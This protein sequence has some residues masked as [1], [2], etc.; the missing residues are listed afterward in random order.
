MQNLAQL[1]PSPVSA[2]PVIGRGI[3]PAAISKAH[4]DGQLTAKVLPSV[5]AV[6][7]EDWNALFP[8]KAED[9]DYFRACELMETPH[10]SFSA[11]AVFDGEMLVAA[12]PIFRMKF[13]LD[14]PLG[15]RVQKLGDWL[16]RHVPKL[17]N[18]PILG[19][20]S[21]WSD[22]CPLG[23]RPGLSADERTAAFEALLAGLSA[24]A[25][26]SGISIL[27][28]KDV[29]SHDAGWAHDALTKA[30]YGR[31]A[32]L[33][34]ASVD[35]PFKN[36]KEF[37]AS[38]PA[39]RR[40]DL[41]RNL[42]SESAVTVEFRDSIEDVY[43]E[44]I[45]LYNQTR[46]RRSAD[47]QSFDE[48]PPGYFKEVMKHLPGKAKVA[49]FRIG[50]ELAGFN[51]FLVGKGE[52]TW[53]F[54]GLQYPLALEHHL[55]FVSWMTMVRYCIRN[56]IPRLQAGQT[57][58]RV[59]IRLGAQLDRSWVYFKHRGAVLGHAFRAVTPFIAFDKLDPDLR[60]LGDEVP[61]RAANDA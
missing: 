18:M 47:F 8:G 3:R 56:R 29:T 4:R 60:E 54:I 46:A 44:L 2:L 14:M 39:K 31:T 10:F 5:T 45:A 33:P 17:I 22:E 59:K 43:D 36:E 1:A 21:P 24:H 7:R 49:L 55:Y 20:G 26:A 40:G 9:W 15:A 16:D 41:R 35:L 34:V 28:L 11:L 12:A 58:Y 38:L 57:T 42:R 27:T 25:A 48:I 32:S 51:F 30:G 50:K 13:R 52:L 6:A 37:F 53:R 23:F 61:Y 19:L